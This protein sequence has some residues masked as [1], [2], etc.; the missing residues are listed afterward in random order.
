MWFRNLRFY[1]FSSPFSLPDDFAER[2]QEQRFRPC[3]RQELASYGW[4]SP[5]GADND[6]LHHR[7][8]DNVL[9][10]ARK[11]EK[12]L[13]ASVI[14]AEVE[15][16]AEQISA[17]QGR[18]V[19]RKE[20]QTIKEDLIHTLLPQAFSKYQ[21][22]WGYLNLE[23]QFIVIDASAASRAE[24]L[25]A[26][27]RSTVGSLPVKPIASEQAL[28]LY[29][30]HWLR[31]LQLPAGFEFGDEVELRG[32]DNDGAVVRCKQLPLDSDEIATHLVHGKQAVKLGLEW[33][34]RLT[35][36]LENDFAVKRF[37]ATDVLMEEKDDL[38]DATPEQQLDVDFALLSGEINALYP[39]LLA[40]VVNTD[41]SE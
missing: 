37:K 32:S 20:K 15:E 26:L 5:F 16:K 34:E 39:E 30:T 28:E 38:V 1:S 19:G 27:L 22:S 10:C 40:T 25:L 18:M 35:F 2:Q 3:G 41:I 12:V 29:M 21:L 31:K 4:Y 6:M 13:P 14:N 24:D 17:E 23:Q 9:F 11:E 8:G 33:R 36:V 7:I